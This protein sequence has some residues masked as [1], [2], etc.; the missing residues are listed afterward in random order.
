MDFIGPIGVLLGVILIIYMTYKGLS[1][2]IAAPLAGI[3]VA[4]LN[5]MNVIEALLGV[6]PGSYMSAFASYILN[7]LSVFLL[8]S[9]LAK[10]MEESDATI[11]IAEVI[12]ARI[13]AKSPYPVLVSVF[14]ITTIL[15]YGGIS[16]FVVMFAVLP[17]ARPLFREL[18]IAWN[19]ITIPL[20]FGAGTITMTMLPG[21][22][23]IQNVIPIQYLGTTL[24]AALVPSL[25]ASALVVGYGMFYMRYALNKS[26]AK[27]ETY[28]T[29]AQ[30]AAITKVD[31]QGP[32]FLLSILPLLT[33][34]VMAVSGSLF[35]ND[36]IKKNIIY[37]ALVV[38]VVLA[39]GLF[40]RHIPK[41]IET[42]NLG[43]S[44]AIMPIV[45]TSA[46]VA[47]GA[48]IMAAP[49][50]SFFSELI[51]KM[52]GNPIFSLSVLNALMSGITGS[53]SGALGIVLPNFGQHYLKA[54]LQPEMI[55]RVSSVSSAILAAVPHSGALISFLALSGLTIKN[56]YKYAI[57]T[58]GISAFIALAVL[59]VYNFLGF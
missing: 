39:Y 38:A 7:F 15:T 6:E 56:A 2:L 33:L 35:G 3:L 8:G 22:P 57:F 19:L 23:A 45:S 53:S 14:I 46:A 9:I 24:T 40:Y 54:G 10:L 50:F 32:S 26:I 55:H 43:A 17:L 25:I 12:L 47:F 27:G 5:N 34:I 42:F 52:P 37:I 11:S 58:V 44:G 4:L 30:D 29:F 21:T 41:H 31:K 28:A 20:W 48:V 36:F 16:L 18:D 13:G 59:V 51:L 1:I 49:G